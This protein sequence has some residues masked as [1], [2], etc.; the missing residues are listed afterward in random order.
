MPSK[1][2]ETIPK[3]EAKSESE[4]IEKEEKHIDKLETLEEEEEKLK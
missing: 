4:Q 2:I 1:I 3:I